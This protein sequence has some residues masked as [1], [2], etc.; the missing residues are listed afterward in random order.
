MID[1]EVRAAI[2]KLRP[3]D[4]FEVSRLYH[5]GRTVIDILNVLHD[6][7]SRGCYV[8]ETSSNRRIDRGDPTYRSAA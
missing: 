2:R 8:I 4:G 5:M 3:G 7:H 1:S 6:I